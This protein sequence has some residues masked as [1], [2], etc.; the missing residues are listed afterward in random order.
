MFSF[1]ERRIEGGN[2]HRLPPTGLNL[3][4][5]AAA[6]EHDDAARAPSTAADRKWRVA[7]S[8][9]RRT[10]HVTRLQLS[11]FEEPERLAVWCPEERPRNVA[12][13]KHLRRNIPQW[14]CVDATAGGREAGSSNPAPI[15]RDRHR[16]SAI[17][18]PRFGHARND[19]ARLD[20]FRSSFEIAIR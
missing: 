9:R 16:R 8:L 7:K 18:I 13:E 4:Q 14:E 12:I 5:H 1:L 17:G 6:R 10:R 20:G 11:V 2:L 15:R 19:V 3:V